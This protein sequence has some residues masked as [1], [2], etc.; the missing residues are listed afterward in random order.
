[1]TEDDLL[2]GIAVDTRISL[3]VIE[4]KNEKAVQEK[5]TALFGKPGVVRPDGI[6]E[7]GDRS[8]FKDRYS[9]GDLI[10]IMQ[11]LTGEG[12][13]P[14]DIAQT[15]ESIRI[16][17]VEE[18]YELVAAINN[19]DIDNMAEETGDLLLQSVLHAN[20]ADRQGEFTMLDVI[21]R[22]CKKL[23]GRHTHIFG[24]N[25]AGNAAEALASWDAAKAKE[26][27]AKDLRAQLESLSQDMPS[28]LYAQK[29][30]KKMVKAGLVNNATPATATQLL[31][32][33]AGSVNAGVDGEVDLR[34]EV[35]KLVGG[36]LA[37]D[38]KTL[39]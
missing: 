21:D 5:L 13:C 14:W 19:N 28:L 30:I 16:N 10:H 34:A 24:D 9:Y 26:K 36:F 39:A 35:D 25:K 22:L 29:A 38:I 7:E 2:G 3:K 1:M 31:S 8:L 6:F 20:I 4:V 27:Q 32:A 33:V 17:A 37:G 15:H 11:R 18:A 23:V 12:G